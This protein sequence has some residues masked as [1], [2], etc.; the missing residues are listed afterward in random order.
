MK[1]QGYIVY[2][3]RKH[4]KP[5]YQGLSSK[6]IGA[7]IRDWE[8]VHKDPIVTPEIAFTGKYSHRLF[9]LYILNK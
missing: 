8:V 3:A 1:S 7:K 5:E 2:K 9:F 4:L 6:E